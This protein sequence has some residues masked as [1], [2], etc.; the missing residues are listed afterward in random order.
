MPFPIQVS[1]IPDTDD[2]VGNLKVSGR[3][4]NRTSQ[5]D[6]YISL[7]S[8]V[9]LLSILITLF[10]NKKIRYGASES[11]QET[12]SIMVLPFENMSGLPD[13]EYVVNGIADELRSQ[14][15]SIRDLRVIS[16]SSSI[17]YSDLKMPLHKINSELGVDYVLEGTVQRSKNVVKINVQLSN[18]KT[19]EVAWS[20]PS[21]QE[22]L[23]DIFILQNKI[24]QQIVDQLKI[25]LSNEEKLQLVKIPTRNADAY[26]SYQKGQE[27]INRGGGKIAEIDTAIR[28]FEEA[29]SLDPKFSLAYVGLSEAYLEYIFWGRY[30]NSQILPKALDAAFKAL[31]LDEEKVEIY[32][33]LGAISFLPL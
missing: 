12:S 5:T 23:E 28:L 6:L 18:S 25:S 24:S 11:D 8:I 29:I 9:L 27:L 3:K 17:Y 15:F 33:A 31:E 20:S 21:F 1:P 22:N 26:I 19:Q 7:L 13:Q 32:S 30:P 4:K 16:R 14:L 2:L 10:I